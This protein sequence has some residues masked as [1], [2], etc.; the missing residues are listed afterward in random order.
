MEDR[1][2]L[3]CAALC[4]CLQSAVR[5]VDG[6]KGEKKGLSVGVFL[7]PCRFLSPFDPVRKVSR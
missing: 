4:Q 5:S 1:A 6:A 3:V 2:C 7:P